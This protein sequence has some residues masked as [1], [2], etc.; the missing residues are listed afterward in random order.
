MPSFSIPFLNTI[1]QTPSLVFAHKA[2]KLIFYRKA[3]SLY[4]NAHSW[5]CLVWGSQ[6]EGPNQNN[7]CTPTALVTLCSLLFTRFQ[8]LHAPSHSISH[9]LSLVLLSSSSL[10]VVI[11]SI[12]L[13]GQI[14][15]SPQTTWRFYQ[16]IFFL[17][18]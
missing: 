18:Y 8:L 6:K 13:L 10:P 7:N 2:L 17:P 3:Q 15:P 9:V 5:T 14:L 1:C 11:S 16:C 4:P 12:F